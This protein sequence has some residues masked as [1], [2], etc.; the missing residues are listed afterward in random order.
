MDQF[1]YP[2]TDPPS[3]SLTSLLDCVGE[4]TQSHRMPPVAS[5]SPLQKNGRYLESRLTG[6]LALL[7]ADAL[8]LSPGSPTADPVCRS[9]GRLVYLR[10]FNHLDRID[11]VTLDF[12]TPLAK[13]M[14]WLFY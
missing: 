8:E 12:M 2:K 4:M 5:W 1:W 14:G 9:P 11:H 6:A 13:V 7:Q 3:A 10:Q